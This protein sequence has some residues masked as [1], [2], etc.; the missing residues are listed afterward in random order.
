MKTI[1]RVAT[2]AILAL[3]ATTVSAET[4]LTMSSWLPAGHPLV[5]DV[6]EPW[7]QSVEEATNGRVK[8]VM[9]PSALG[10]PKVHYDIARE[11]QADIT[12]GGH[13]Y[14]PGRF[15]LYKMVEF[16]FGGD[17]AVSTSV[18]Y[19]T[20]YNNYL[21]SAGEH[22]DVKLL[23]LFTHGPGH[24]HNGKHAVN[25]ASDLDGMKLR[26]GG[27]VMSDIAS[28]LGAVPLQKPSS[29]SYE[30][31]SSGVAD[32]VLFPLESVPAFNIDKKVKHTTLVP[33]GMYNF[34][35]FLVMNRDRFAELPEEDRKAIES[36]SGESFARLA[37][38]MWDTQDAKGLATIKANGNEITTANESFQAEI[39]NA[40][41]PMEAEWLN[42]AAELGIDGKAA[43]AAFRKLSHQQDL[44]QARLK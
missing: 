13:G 42:T 14:T 17:S 37:G 31:I 24:I 18:A 11:G 38:N 16:P 7:I 10:H 41:A 9:L 20:V 30:L 19:W 15:K 44:E 28:A 40:S 26:V 6:M 27:G 33:G 36:V 8:V 4:R 29:S 39:R 35:F 32:G 43:L 23:G 34:S 22:Q 21:K 25:A 2:P 5:K 3:L 1:L 12:Y